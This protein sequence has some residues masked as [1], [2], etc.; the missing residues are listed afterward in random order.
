MR[1][2]A[3]EPGCGACG[4]GVTY[5]AHSGGLGEPS[6]PTMGLCHSCWLDAVLVNGAKSPGS[7]ECGALAFTRKNGPEV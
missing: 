7:T 6:G 4:R 5:P 2:H 3:A 1:R